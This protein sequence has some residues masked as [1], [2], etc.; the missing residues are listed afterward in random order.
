MGSNPREAI[1]WPINWQSCVASEKVKEQMHALSED[2][3]KE[4]AEKAKV[5]GGGSGIESW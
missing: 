5:S 2:M 4:K 3:Q 1:F